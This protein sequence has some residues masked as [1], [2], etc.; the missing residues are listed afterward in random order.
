MTK[1]NFVNRLCLVATLLAATNL[2]AADKAGAPA[3]EDKKEIVPIELSESNISASEKMV[4]DLYTEIRQKQVEDKNNLPLMH[5]ITQHPESFWDTLVILAL[6]EEDFSLS[7][8][9]WVITEFSK[10][11]QL[12]Q[13]KAA[14][15]FEI[16]LKAGAND[17]RRNYF[18]TLFI[19]IDIAQPSGALFSDKVLSQLGY[20]HGT[21]YNQ[22]LNMVEKGQITALKTVL[23]E[24]PELAISGIL[25]PAVSRN[26]PKEKSDGKGWTKSYENE[27]KKYDFLNWLLRENKRYVTGANAS[28]DY[29]NAIKLIIETAGESLSK[30]LL[31]VKEL[32]AKKDGQVSK[33]P[34]EKIPAKVSKVTE[35]KD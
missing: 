10:P 1:V 9:T 11:R 8:L 30:E 15:L 7:D 16:V 27:T 3:R 33:K 23:K 31:E 29:V 24:F 28:P 35:Q 14:K 6:N 12:K 2:V 34:D 20:I 13:E 18:R 21:E 17:H 25:K 32:V 26:E 19:A 4:I 5:F 22:L